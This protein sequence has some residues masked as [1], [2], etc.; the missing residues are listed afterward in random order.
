MSRSADFFCKWPG[1]LSYNCSALSLQTQ[2]QAVHARASVACPSEAG[3]SQMRPV[4]CRL[5]AA[6]SGVSLYSWT[7]A[8]PKW[9]VV[10]RW[11]EWEMV[12]LGSGSPTDWIQRHWAAFTV[13]KHDL[14][15]VMLVPRISF[16]FRTRKPKVR[17]HFESLH[18]W[19]NSAILPNTPMGEG[20]VSHSV[21][22]ERTDT[23][24]QT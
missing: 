14:V 4:G 18:R 12:S 20:S 17:G 15:L 2:P 23:H 19:L 24:E 6:A 5:P 7:W 11:S 16:T 22:P 1:S 10:M 3:S 8:L 9:L 21:Y 13:T